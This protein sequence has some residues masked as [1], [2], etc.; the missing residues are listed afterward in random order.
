MGRLKLGIYSFI[1]DVDELGLESQTTK[2]F[3]Y[4]ELPNNLKPLFNIVTKG[5]SC[6]KMI[7]INVLSNNSI[8]SGVLIQSGQY[9]FEL[10]TLDGNVFSVYRNGTQI[11]FVYNEY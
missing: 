8:Y 6:E 10:N 9:T 2:N 7:F 4:D 11:T 1:I 3:S 5:K